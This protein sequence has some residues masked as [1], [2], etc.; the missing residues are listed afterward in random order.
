MKH[1][2]LILICTILL[3]LVTVSAVSAQDNAITKDTI[4]EN[5]NDDVS[6]AITLEDEHTLSQNQDFD[7]E[8][9]SCDNNKDEVIKS[10]SLKEANSDFLT[11]ENAD[12]TPVNFT[13][14][15]Y[16]D[17]HIYGDTNL[18]GFL[19][20]KYIENNVSVEIDG[21]N[22]N[23]T[24][25]DINDFNLWV[26]GGD[27]KTQMGYMVKFSDL[28][29]GNHEV[30]IT[31]PGDSK[32]NKTQ[33]VKTITVNNKTQ[34]PKLK[35]NIIIDSNGLPYP[36]SA[37]DTYR[38][39]GI[40]VYFDWS[41]YLDQPT[42]KATVYVDNKYV[43][44][45]DANKSYHMALDKVWKYYTA[46]G[47]HS[48]KVVYQGDDNYMAATETYSFYLAKYYCDITK[49]GVVE[50]E[51]SS[52]VSGVLS[53]KVNG[54]NIA[55]K[56][57]KA[58]YASKMTYTSELYRTALKGLK[59]NVKNTVVVNFKAKSKKNSFTEYFYYKNGK[60]TPIPNKVTLTLKKVTVKKSA[61]ELVLTA[62][63]KKAINPLKNK[64]VTF[65]FNG[66]TYKAKTNDK[67]VAKVTVK[68]STLKKLK[69]G[70]TVTYQATYLKDTVKKTTK[71]KK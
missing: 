69:V 23:Y 18:F 44:K 53:I 31:Y 12:Q 49:K 45:F 8:K 67:G 58:T 4:L 35:L 27:A 39:T 21:K 54:K 68:K 2:K 10:T 46:N 7:N 16:D 36:W 11:D 55:T 51:L 56:N 70:E 30:I 20:P 52:D 29:L 37:A 41:Y 61:K 5:T 34:E 3:A 60:V 43:G 15:F 1:G 47:F 64:K 17:Y 63:L 14:E 24:V 22:Y 65:K 59:K 62:T 66:V 33:L 38:T 28:I 50:T 42:G 25:Y 9:T 40:S 26:W 6:K 32:Y 71:V 13:I 57:I 48:V 19:M